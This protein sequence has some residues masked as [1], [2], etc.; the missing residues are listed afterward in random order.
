LSSLS[1]D[2]HK[3]ICVLKAFST[4][5]CTSRT[6]TRATRPSAAEFRTATSQNPKIKKKA[7]KG[8]FRVFAKA[9][10]DEKGGKGINVPF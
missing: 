1:A 9:L 2:H 3:P 6:A 5:A 4:S 7:Y 8:T 10:F